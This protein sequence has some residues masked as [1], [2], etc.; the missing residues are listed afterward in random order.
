MMG[1][2]EA[3]GWEDKDKSALDVETQ[4]LGSMAGRQRLSE[5]AWS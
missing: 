4:E 2:V 5:T 3:G 1:W